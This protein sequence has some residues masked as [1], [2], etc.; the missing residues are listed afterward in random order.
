MNFLD[1]QKDNIDYQI[2][3]GIYAKRKQDS[4]KATLKGILSQTLF[5]AYL[6][7]VCIQRANGIFDFNFMSCYFAESFRVLLSWS[8]FV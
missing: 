5:S 1:D 6:S 7:V 8:F 3:Y 2:I 4:F